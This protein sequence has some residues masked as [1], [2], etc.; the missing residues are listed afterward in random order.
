MSR[1][2]VCIGA[3]KAGTTSLYALMQQHPAVATT[4]IKET[5][6]FSDDAKYSNGFPWFLETYFPN[7][8]SK[9]LL[10]EADP[11]Y[12]CSST[13]LERIR[14]CDPQA[15]IVIMLRNPAD[16]AFSQWLYHVQSAR[17]TETFPEALAMEP[18]RIRTGEAAV[19]RWGY[20]ERGRYGKH[21][22]QVFDYF[23]REQTRCVL[24]ERFIRNQAGEFEGLA[25]WLGLPSASIAP[26]T[27]NV[28]GRPRSALIARVLY[29][30]NMHSLRRALGK[31]FGSGKIKQWVLNSI[32][33]I[34]V[35]AY[36]EQDRPRFDPI[37][38]RRILKELEA[39]IAYAQQLT[40]L[41]LSIWREEHVT[42]A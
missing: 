21:I 22:A 18:Q 28:T 26:T 38:R 42:A 30:E 1:L 33:R 34:N 40:G 10:F 29:D 14:A 23:P 37:L 2:V 8:V 36:H 15:R 7:S 24:F 16:R 17:S 4:T 27:E 25:D 41:D 5:N 32:N 31:S 6:F 20:I 35:A 19:R 13:C 39:D 9:Q 11:G 12:M 3:A